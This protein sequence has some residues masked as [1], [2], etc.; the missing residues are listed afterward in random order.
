[1]DGRFL[2][3]LSK[4]NYNR[5]SNPL[6]RIGSYL[7]CFFIP[8]FSLFKAE[9]ALPQSLQ[10]TLKLK[11]VEV[12]ASYPVNNNGFKRVKM[13]S[14]ILMGNINGDL[15]GILSQYST[16]FIKSYGNGN[17]ST[18]S[19]RGTTAH[20]TQVEWNGITLNS[21]MLGQL[22]L[23]QV[24]VAQFN[25]VEILYGAAGIANASGA[26]G[27]IV[28][29][30]TNPD[31]N[32]NI[33]AMIAQTIASFDT[34]S[35]NL[36]VST[37]TSSFQSITKGNFTTS[38]NNFPFYNDYTGTEMNQVNGSYSQGGFSEDV[39]FKIK[40][41]NLL[42]AKIWYSRD[43]RNI[44]PI[45]TN[46]D[47]DHVENQSDESL[48]S[49]VEWK[50]V[51]HNYS[52][53]VRS[54]LIDQFMKYSNDTASYNHQ[55]YSWS[56]RIRFTWVGTKKWSIRPGIDV[57]SDWVNSDSYASNKSRNTAG[58]FADIGYEISPKVKTSGVLRLDVIDGLLMPLVF[59][60]GSEYHPFKK[61]NI[62]FSGNVSSNYR[63]PS[64]NDLYWDLFGNPD[65]Q[66][67]QDYAVEAGTVYNFLSK[68]TKF[69]IETSLTGYFSWMH[70][71]IVWAPVEGNSYIWKPQNITEVY[72]R[73]LEAGIN[74]I[75]KLH[76]LKFDLNTNY[77]FCRSTNQKV[78]SE[79]DQSLGKQLIYIPVN[80]LNAT[81][82]SSWKNFFLVWNFYY[83]SRRYTGTDNETYMPGYNLSNLFLGKEF[84]LK[85]F[86]LSLQLDIN[87]LFDLDYQSIAN[88]PMPGRNYSVTLK[89]RFNR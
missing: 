10:D 34:Y 31:W 60:V 55:Y 47:P 50:M 43:Y 21:P 13:D 83:T 65:L 4:T 71:L 64:L 44:P 56:N 16:I 57:V 82:N 25:G 58:L 20:H 17:L 23:S 53:L 38:A 5:T 66:P 3:K 48:R 7:V 35:T 42:T 27:G 86:M 84:H 80:T 24:P 33:D 22:D 45:T 18:P 28:N 88:R 14:I 12:M 26:F 54:A 36:S 9:S 11:E 1:M 52:V 30:V 74:I 73:G 85:N 46:I 40:Q 59:T 81:L 78:N 76:E 63:Y 75:Y 89:G 68:D 61:I 19:F 39:F 51:Q 79:N 62:S 67:E 32:N 6:M 15:S 69:F 72:A 41:K 70:D 37:G 29:L 8:V 87:N 77:N 49:L 2:R